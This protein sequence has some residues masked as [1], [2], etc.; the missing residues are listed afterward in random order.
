MCVTPTAA[1]TLFSRCVISRAPDIR[2][3]P[4]AER[5]KILSFFAFVCF[6]RRGFLL[7]TQAPELPKGNP[8]A[9]PLVLNREAQGIAELKSASEVLR[10]AIPDAITR[11]EVPT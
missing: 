7:K 3:H 5:C 8:R 11:V 2:S 9:R 10:G 1:G 6:V 4:P